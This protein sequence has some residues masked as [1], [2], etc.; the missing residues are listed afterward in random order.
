MSSLPAASWRSS[1]LYHI[2]L[3]GLDAGGGYSFCELWTRQKDGSKTC[4]GFATDALSSHSELRGVVCHVC[5][6]ES[7]GWAQLLSPCQVTWKRCSGRECI[8]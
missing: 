7:W 5:E 1:L 2:I 3:T 4:P 8:L 6:A